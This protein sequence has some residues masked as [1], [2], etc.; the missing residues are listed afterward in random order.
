MTTAVID[1]IFTAHFA[2]L[3]RRTDGRIVKKCCFSPYP[4]PTKTMIKSGKKCCLTHKRYV[5]RN[6]A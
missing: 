5:S 3:R 1:A 2:V 6:V 4:V